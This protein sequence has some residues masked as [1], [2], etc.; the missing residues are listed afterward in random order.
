LRKYLEEVT[1]TV[2]GSDMPIF[3][4]FPMQLVGLKG[5]DHTGNSVWIAKTHHPFPNGPKK[6][7]I[8]TS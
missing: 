2:T 5:E 8:T 1:G 4:S 7:P 6:A 3:V